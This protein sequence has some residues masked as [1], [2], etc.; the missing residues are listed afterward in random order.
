M[1]VFAAAENLTDERY[2][3][4]N[5][6]TATGSLFNIGP[7]FLYRIGLRLNFPAERQ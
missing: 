4:A 7:P 2:A 5:T 6:P 1:E 3:I